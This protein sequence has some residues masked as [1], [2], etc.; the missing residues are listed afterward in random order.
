MD[1]NATPWRVLE[2]PVGTTPVGAPDRSS[3]TGVAMVRPPVDAGRRGRCDRACGR[4]LRARGRLEFDGIGGRRR[5]V[6]APER[7]GGGRDAA[8][9]VGSARLLG[10]CSWS[11]SS[12]QSTTPACSDYPG[13]H[14]SATSS[15]R[16]AVTA[17]GWT[18]SVPAANST[19]RPSFAMAT[20][21]GSRRVTT[22]SG[23]ARRRPVSARSRAR[24]G[25][26]VRSD[27]PEPRHARRNSTPCPASGR[28][29]RPRSWRRA[30]SSRSRPSTTCGRG[31]SSARRRSPTSRTS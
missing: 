2:D 28:R 16:R 12:G 24:P 31:S 23:R 22:R 20:R 21:S 27:R 29:P 19:W 26:T 4:C 11:R 17:R 5:W 1:P 9:R 6:A 25:A 14:G 13:I 30:T 15:R 3:R 10:R 8:G 18:R 7:L